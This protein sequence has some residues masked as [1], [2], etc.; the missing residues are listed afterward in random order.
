MANSKAEFTFE[1]IISLI[2]VILVVITISI[3]LF[4]AQII[5]YIK[6]LP[7]YQLP[8][9]EPGI[10]DDISSDD[11]ADME[12]ILCIIEVG[13][14][15]VESKFFGRD[16]NVIFIG[17][18]PN[19]EKTKLIWKADRLNGI[20]ELDKFGFNKRV[21]K[22]ED[23]SIDSSDFKEGEINLEI[24]DQLEKL[25]GAK[26]IIGNKLCKDGNE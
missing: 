11:D 6:I 3:F 15:E 1:Q 26:L 19:Y 14:V 7:G 10:N 18:Y 4:R 9:G 2:L 13:K 5:N 16:K 21:G 17:S 25:D 22:V 23:G 20:I 8:E 24:I 12:N